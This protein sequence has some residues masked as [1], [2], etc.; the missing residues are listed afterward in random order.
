MVV[1]TNLITSVLAKNIPASVS[2]QGVLCSRSITAE[3]Y[4]CVNVCEKNRILHNVLVSMSNSSRLKR[5]SINNLVETG[6]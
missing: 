1:Y 3:S 4:V 6:K 5:K 2:V